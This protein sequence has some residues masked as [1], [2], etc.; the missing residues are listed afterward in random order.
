MLLIWFVWNWRH[1]TP[2]NHNK[3]E[4]YLHHCDSFPCNDDSSAWLRVDLNNAHE[5]YKIGSIASWHR[6]CH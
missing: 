5:N 1:S 2:M 3:V 6:F 4:N